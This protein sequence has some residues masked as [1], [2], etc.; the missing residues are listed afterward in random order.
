MIFI[1]ADVFV[2]YAVEG[3][4]NHEKAAKIVG[5]VMEGEFGRVFTSDY[6]FD[7]TVTVTLVRSKSLEKAATAGSIIR[8]S[9]EILKIDEAVFEDSWEIFRNQGNSR[10]SFTDCTSISLAKERGIEHVATF[11]KELKRSG[12]FDV[13]E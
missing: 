10:L 9:V 1:D 13:V 3:D 12:L 6:V 8:G 4:S 7:E 5:R 2:A 11:D